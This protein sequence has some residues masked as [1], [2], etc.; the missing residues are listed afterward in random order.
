MA[1][2][3]AALIVMVAI[4]AAGDETG[5]ERDHLH[6]PTTYEAIERRGG[7]TIATTLAL[8]RPCA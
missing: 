1:R 4:A 8:A 3:E 2:I 7:R 6:A 5:E